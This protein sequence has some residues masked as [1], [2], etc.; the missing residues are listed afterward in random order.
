MPERSSAAE[1]RRPPAILSGIP[2]IGSPEPE[3]TPILACVS[4]YPHCAPAAPGPGCA[5]PSA[6]PRGFTTVELIT[7][8]AVTLILMGTLLPLVALVSNRA[9]QHR[10]QQMA[11]QLMLAIET[12][13]TADPRRRYPLHFASP[14]SLYV[15]AVV[16]TSDIADL[17]LPLSRQPYPDAATS[18][19]LI[20]ADGSRVG[21]LG[22]LI[23]M[24]LSAP[25]SVDDQGRLLDPWSRPWN[26]QLIRP[27]AAVPASTV[28]W[29]WDA[30]QARPRAWNAL[31]KCPAPFPYLWSYGKAG[32]T[33]DPA[34]W[35]HAQ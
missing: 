15:A 13:R 31:D 23:D 33:G 25:D 7:V 12:Y 9:K 28:D 27:A 32:L 20:S 35:I 16:P 2:R 10:A 8:V 3:G 24:G 11:E 18:P 30:D 17:P 21:V 34:G 6:V 29:N 4:A 19:A 1:V 14:P 22:M 5:A 26:Y